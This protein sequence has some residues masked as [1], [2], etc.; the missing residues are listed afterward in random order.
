[1]TEE[2]GMDLSPLAM[3]VFDWAGTM[4]D[5]GCKAP[6]LALANAFALEGLSIAERDLRADMGLAKK[7]HVRALLARSVVAE[8]WLA[9]KGQ[10]SDEGD[11]ARIYKNLEGL[12]TE[13][14][15][16]ASQLIPG[17]D[18]LVRTLRGSGLKI[19]S[20]TGYTRPMMDAVR[21][22]AA[23]QGYLPDLVT[24]AGDTLQGR[25]SP[26]MMYRSALELGVWPMS[27]VVKVDDA[28]SGI[29]EGLAA[30]AWT[31]GL[32]A[33]GNGVGLS[34]A[35]LAALSASER[36]ARIAQSRSILEEA[37]AHY[38]VDTV[39]DCLPVLAHIASR[40]RAN[41]HP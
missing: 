25:P 3:V 27:A 35:E 38:V 36:R 40:L 34:E 15:A 16:E 10:P 39:A 24:C 23:T 22:R 19:A 14:A 33:T 21:Q 20:T 29:A 26:L 6:V 12:I 31:I 28:A 18:T 11:V 9:Q 2:A 13:T 4:V 8:A 41:A 30:G 1:M 7:D 37:G 32:A 5:F 17:A